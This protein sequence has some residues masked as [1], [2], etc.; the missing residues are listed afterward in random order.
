MI[1]FPLGSLAHVSRVPSEPLDV[2]FMNPGTE[3]DGDPRIRVP[4]L[5]RLRSSVPVRTEAIR[6]H[7]RKKLAG[8]GIHFSEA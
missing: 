3:A 5:P 7:L 1:H 6:F 8:L 2:I 4:K